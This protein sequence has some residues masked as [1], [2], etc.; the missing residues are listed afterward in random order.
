MGKDV[1][2]SGRKP[3]ES[4]ADALRRRLERAIAEFEEI[5]LHL[6]RGQMAVESLTPDLL[7]VLLDTKRREK[8]SDATKDGI[9][10]AKARG[11]KFGGARKRKPK[12]ST[13]QV[14]RL[15]RASPQRFHPRT[16]RRG[17]GRFTS[18]HQQTTSKEEKMSIYQKEGSK[19]FWYRFTYRGKRYQ[20][21]TEGRE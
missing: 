3:G 19:Y 9:K 20:R 13:Q 1:L 5:N 2:A 21:S 11:V 15:P 6:K 16:N 8:I 17:F 14:R 18:A 4:L 7:N 12:L 10:R